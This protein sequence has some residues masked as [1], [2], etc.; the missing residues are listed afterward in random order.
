MIRSSYRTL[1]LALA[2][3]V[4][5]LGG[6]ALAAQPVEIVRD[7]VYGHKDGLA[8]TFDVLRPVTGG[9]GAGVLFMVSGGWVSS[10]SPPEQSVLRFE[11]L[12]ERGFTLF[13][14]RHGSSPRYFVPEAVEDV[15]RATRYIRYHAA[16][17]GVDK[18]RLGVFGGSAGGHL[19]LMLGNASSE[20]DPNAT[21]P[22]L[23]ESNRV[24]SVVAYYPPVDLRQMARGRNAPP[25]ANGAPERFPALNFDRELASGVSPLLFVSRDDPPTL[26]VHGTADDLVPLRNSEIIY[27]AFREQ[28]VTTEL[29]IL[30]GAGHGF[31]G[32]DATRATNAM[33]DWF[34]RTLVHGR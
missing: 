14:V 28:G 33:M 8:M 34:E 6:G 1:L 17:W 9:N 18:E 25:P 11:G 19:S 16:Q 21:V 15:R 30:E 5:L 27:Q 29:I 24:A 26:L 3:A 23:R 22:F 2:L 7:V 20:G 32:D 31:R 13:I 4:Q 10:Y 12:L